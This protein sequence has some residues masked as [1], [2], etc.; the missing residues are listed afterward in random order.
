MSASTNAQ[1]GSPDTDHAMPSPDGQVPDLA[2]A[3][4]VCTHTHSEVALESED[5][6]AV[7]Y[8]DNDLQFEV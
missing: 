2:N 6:Q 7:Q 3:E 4:R 8:E 1:D 5:G